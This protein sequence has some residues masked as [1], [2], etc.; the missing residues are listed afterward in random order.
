MDTK[1]FDAGKS[2]RRSIDAAKAFLEHALKNGRALDKIL[3]EEAAS[4]VHDAWLAQSV[5]RE[6]PEDIEKKSYA[7]LPDDIK[8]KDREF[9]H[10][11]MREL[12]L[13]LPT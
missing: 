8:E 12:G 7:D 11:A 13:S 1:K 5:H 4:C 9:V 2:R 10:I 3:F 6:T